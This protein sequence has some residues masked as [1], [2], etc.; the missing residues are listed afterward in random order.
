MVNKFKMELVWHNCATYLPKEA[1][2]DNLI[3]TNGEDVYEAFWYAPDGFMIRSKSLDKW[4]GLYDDLD[5]W[6]WADLHQT[7]Q[8]YNFNFCDHEW[9]ATMYSY[10][11]GGLVSTEFICKHCGETMRE[12]SK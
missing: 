1:T 9:V 7:V 11:D 5:K 12:Y 2:N 4:L 6:W 3:A 10:Y 8:H